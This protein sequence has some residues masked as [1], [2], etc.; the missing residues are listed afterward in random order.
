MSLEIKV[1]AQRETDLFGGR[2]GSAWLRPAGGAGFRVRAAVGDNG[3]FWIRPR[4]T[5]QPSVDHK[6][7]PTGVGGWFDPAY[8]Q[9]EPPWTKCPRHSWILWWIIVLFVG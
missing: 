4:L 3:L 5:E 7:P 6:I 1:E 8:T 9:G 2:R